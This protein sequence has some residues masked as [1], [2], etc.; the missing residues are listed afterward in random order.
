MRV[1]VRVR[2]EIE[3]WKSE[4]EWERVCEM[5]ASATELI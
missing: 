3:S 5:E 4:G 1:R 2:V